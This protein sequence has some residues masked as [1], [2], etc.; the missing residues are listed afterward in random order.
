MLRARLRVLLAVTVLVSLSLA[1]SRRFGPRPVL[2][3]FLDPANGVWA[4]A[5]VADPSG[6]T[7]ARMPGLA[8]EVRIVFD[9][10][11][12][13]HIFAAN[14]LDAWRAL[15]FAVARDRLFQL[16]LTWR[17]GAGRLSELLGPRAL[18][19]DRMARRLGLAWSADR[20]IARADTRAPAMRA[21]RAY[22]EG[23]NHWIAT[24]PAAAL[25]LEYRLL[26]RDPARWEV[27]YSAY[28]LA[29]MGYTLT[30]WDPARHRIRAAALVGD[31]AADALFPVNSPIQEP[32]Q[33]NGQPAARFDFR[34]VPPPA[35]PRPETETLVRAMNQASI[36]FE[37][38]AGAG[39][40]DGVGSNNWVVGPRRSA[41]GR[42][43][44][45]GDPHLELTLPSIWYEAHVV[46]PDSLDV[47]GVTLPGSPGI[48]IG[49]N[50]DVAWSF[51]N[52]GG[53]VLDMYLETVDDAARPRRY[54]LDGAWKT[55]EARREVYAGPDG[56]LLAEDT[57]Y[58][59]HRGPM[60]PGE[61]GWH[62][63]RWTLHDI[64][65]DRG[66]FLQL[67][68]ARSVGDWLERWRQFDAPAQN[69]V[70]ADR[71]GTIA[72]RSTGLHPVRPG[73]GRGDVV[74]AGDSSMSDWKGFL[75]LEY[76]PFS[77]NPP[78]GFLASANQQPVD[79]RVN[80]SYFGAQ[81]PSP[82]RAMRINDLLR[83][84]S[85]VT[86]DAM[87]RYQTD[88]GNA[89]ADFFVPA[90]LAAAA[91]TPPPDDT[92]R[93]AAR[94]LADWDRR[95]TKANERAVLFEAAM[96]ALADAIWDELIPPG[97]S[98]GPRGSAAPSAAVLASLVDDSTSVWWD[99]RR[100]PERETRDVLLARSLR[101]GFL[102]T[103]Q[104]HGPP[105]AGGWRWERIRKANINHV[106][107]IPSLSA[108]GI[109]VQGGNGN[110]NPSSG[111]GTHGASWR[112]VVELGDTMRASAIYP[113]GQSGN[114]ASRRYDDRIPKWAAGEL[115]SA[116]F[117]RTP[118]AI[119]PA[120]IASVVILRPAR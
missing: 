88:P 63:L 80:P 7:R 62:S 102:A 49:W 115:D 72:I 9:D 74:R 71:R 48:T 22:A 106:L 47:A 30:H 111:N 41:S 59:T 24:M 33:P 18:D 56:S 8:A 53:D 109:P 39:E 110:L 82:W 73:D 93:L 44:L 67:N 94:L 34:P 17:A 70:V 92:L 107:R 37:I 118:D 112:M 77:L 119:P 76:Y 29:R 35:A 116:L 21:F 66:D 43:L 91:A 45:A 3:P 113:G 5:R 104:A 105:D 28:L 68:A 69:G 10:R 46:V 52:T 25:P 38:A 54:R 55:L 89:R 114:P 20:A 84:D 61:G 108:R 32:I 19:G 99:D 50:R 65:P 6:T 57:V 95:Y 120:R 23:I 11:G 27:Q 98:A 78:Q 96:E 58:F 60:M 15:G 26:G 85:A 97:D 103:V 64:R 81:W 42:A 83:Q 4:L 75:P 2:G 13:P 100:T 51:T 101:T 16:E 40:D 79:P 14:E 31:E 12:V 87:R 90:L 117:P 36:A 1:L 86:P